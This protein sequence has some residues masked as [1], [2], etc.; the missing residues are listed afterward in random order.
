MALRAER[1]DVDTPSN[2]LPRKRAVAVAVMSL[3]AAL[4]AGHLVAAFVGPPASPFV[5]VGNWVRDNTPHPVVEW[6]KDTFGTADKLVLFIGVTA[7]VLGLTVLAGLLSRTRPLPGLVIAA[8]QGVLG[9]VAVLSR[10]DLGQLGLLAPAASVVA[11]LVT[12][13]WLHSKA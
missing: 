3:L 7:V 9:F 8:A 4:A 10:P 1:R 2:R 5:A 11:G 6:A 12:F 13:S